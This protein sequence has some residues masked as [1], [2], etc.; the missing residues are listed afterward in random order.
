V[1]VAVADASP[2]HYLVLI[3]AIELLPGLFE[4]V[5][6]P[7]T[8]HAELIQPATP[9][10]VRDWAQS[11]PAWL[12][13]LPVQA[14]EDA[15]LQALD[16][17]ERAAIVLSKSLHPDLILMD[18]R[19]GRA[20]ARARGFVVMGTPGV[21][22]SAARR[23]LLDLEAAVAALRATNFHARQELLDTLLARRRA[24]SRS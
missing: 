19:A 2:L 10:V 23:D 21:L 8:V 4:Q 13:V 16:D 22:D 11:P 24:G 6:V 9:A 5:L 1:R 20:A 14:D 18:D 17:G 3:D 15:T 12:T 7:T